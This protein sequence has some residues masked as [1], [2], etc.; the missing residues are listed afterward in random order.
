[1]EKGY[2]LDMRR[3]E[4]LVVLDEA[5]PLAVWLFKGLGGDDDIAL[6]V[7][8]LPPKTQVAYIDYIRAWKR[9]TGAGTE[10]LE[11]ILAD[12]D[13]RD[14]QFTYLWA[15]PDRLADM[16]RLVKWYAGHGFEVL[17]CTEPDRV[18]MRRTRRPHGQ[19]ES[20]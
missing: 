2:C 4:A 17:P 18:P 7:D 19:E 3:A 10:L 16:S 13:A 15:V 6:A 5:R 1:M 11:T 20:D 12:M 9:G 14:M 8:R